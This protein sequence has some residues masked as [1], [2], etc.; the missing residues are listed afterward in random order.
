VRFPS[1]REPSQRWSSGPAP[2]TRRGSLGN[3]SPDTSRRVKVGTARISCRGR[4]RSPPRSQAPSRTCVSRAVTYAVASE[5]LQRT[6]PERRLVALSPAFTYALAGGTPTC[7]R[8][9]SIARTLEVFRTIGTL[10]MEE[11]VFDGNACAREPSTEEISR[12]TRWRIKGWSRVDAHDL[13]AVKG[14]LARGRPVIFAMAVGPKFRAHRGAGV[15]STLDI[16]PGL[17]GHAMVLIGYDDARDAFRL[18]N[19]HG[20]DWGDGGYAWISYTAWQQAAFGSRGFV[21]E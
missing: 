13:S 10:P 20:R 2:V 17:D 1:D 4:R 19:S 9:T 7:Q 12:A 15:F 14:Q 8:G 6:G 18:Q 3:A 21:I 5:A 11:F 16:G